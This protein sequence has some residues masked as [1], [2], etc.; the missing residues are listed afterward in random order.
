MA[1]FS[2]A[3]GA[4]ALAIA[5]WTS[6]CSDGPQERTSISAVEELAAARQLGSDYNGDGRSDFAIYRRASSGNTM[7]VNVLPARA[8]GTPGD[9]PVVGDFDGDNRTDIMVWRPSVGVWYPLLSSTGFTGGAAVQWG[10]SGDIPLA[11]DYDGDGKSDRTVFRQGTWYVLQSSNGLQL[12]RSWGVASDVP[13]SGD[14][15]GDKKSDLAVWR[16]STGVWWILTSSS[17]FTASQSQQWGTAGDIPV[18]GDYDGDGITDFAVYR[19]SN[20]TF[21]L[22]RST[23]HAMTATPYGYGNDIPVSLDVDGDK[24]TDIALYRPATGQWFAIE[25]STGGPTLVATY[26]G[27]AGDIP[28]SAPPY[29]VAMMANWAAPPPPPPVAAQYQ[30]TYVCPFPDYGAGPVTDT[31]TVRSDGT[32]LQDQMTSRG[33]AGVLQYTFYSYDATTITFSNRDYG[34]WYVITLPLSALSGGDG[35]VVTEMFSWTYGTPG[36]TWSTPCVRQ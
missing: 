9:V 4:C 21:Y 23:T 27:V 34:Y 33:D 17:N 18:T 13:V 35:V 8:W 7:Y 25:S 12:S 6:G 1:R 19:P 14:F 2:T 28:V 20:A 32:S 16:P 31:L 24:K 15:D 29:Y 26:G 10:E 36:N 30:Y 22:I 5:M 11:G 3:V